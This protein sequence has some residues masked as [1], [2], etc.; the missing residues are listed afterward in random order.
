MPIPVVT[1]GR[2]EPLLG[3][4]GLAR[5]EIKTDRFTLHCGLGGEPVIPTDGFGG[6]TEVP[7][8]NNT[9]ITEWVGSP[10]LRLSLPLFLDGYRE[11]K[12]VQRDLDRLLS[13]GRTRD[14]DHEPPAFRVSGPIPYS[15][16]KFVLET[17][18]DFGAT[19]RNNRGKLLRQALTLSLLEYGRPDRIK[20]G[21]RPS[22]RRT[23][24]VREG[25]TIRKIAVKLF[26]DADRAREIAKLNGIR[27]IRKPLKPGRVI[28]I[29][30]KGRDG[31]RR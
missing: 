24:T 21:R 13:L 31:D 17:T 18:P 28:R 27:D 5:V 6:W 14:G 16:T 11:G 9:P 15:G 20:V 10:A 8:P 25:D 29:D 12:S 3:A 30:E 2:G 4:L 19:I 22:K 1:G 26:G 23:Y 7:R